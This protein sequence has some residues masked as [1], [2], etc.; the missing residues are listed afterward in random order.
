MNGRWLAAAAAMMG[1]FVFGCASA[2]PGEDQ[3]S[4]SAR[5]MTEDEPSASGR[6][7]CTTEAANVTSRRFYFTEEDCSASGDGRE[8]GISQ[9][10]ATRLD[11]TGVNPTCERDRLVVFYVDARGLCLST[12]IAIDDCARE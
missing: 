2:E 6:C 10:I 11:V 5:V 7:A 3:D 9:G 4:Q 1:I 8:G 12:S